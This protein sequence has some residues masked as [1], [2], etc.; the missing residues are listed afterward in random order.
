MYVLESHFP[1][2]LCFISLLHALLKCAT[3]LA[4]AERRIYELLAQARN[5]LGIGS[6]IILEAVK[7]RYEV[8]ASSYHVLL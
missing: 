7:S 3:H 6:R 8:V 2:F 1:V 4:Q 5:L